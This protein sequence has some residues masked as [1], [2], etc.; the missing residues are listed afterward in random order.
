MTIDDFFVKKLNETLKRT[1]KRGCQSDLGRATGMSR[2][3]VSNILS[4]KRGSNE[5]F[6]RK[7]AELAGLDY[8]QIVREYNMQ[9]QSG[10]CIPCEIEYK[11]ID[12]EMQPTTAE[13]ASMVAHILESQSAINKV[14]LVASVK[15][16]FRAVQGEIKMSDMETEMRTMHSKLDAL[17]EMVSAIAPGF[18]KKRDPATGF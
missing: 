13:T 8:E 11:K 12:V 2:G 16:L 17:M 9:S 14:A 7:A 1:G 18:D 5:D 3:N 4:G 6:R 10:H 15:A